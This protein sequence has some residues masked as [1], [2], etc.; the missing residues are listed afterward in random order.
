MAR[1]I[2][3]GAGI[4]GL[5]CAWSAQRRGW[6]VTLVDRDFE[7][8]RAS[9]GNAGSIAV[10]EC[11]P[12]SLAGLGLQPLRWLVDPLGPLSIRATHAPR[13]LPWFMALRKVG[14]GANHDRIAQTLAAINARALPDLKTLLAD[15]GLGAELHRHGALTVYETRRALE[16]DAEAWAL[17]RT[18]GVRWRVIH[19]AELRSLEPGLAPVFE[20]AVMLEDCAHVSDPKRIVER[21]R[22][23]VQAL[24]AELVSGRVSAVQLQGQQASAVLSDGRALPADRLLVAAGAW[25]ARLAGTLGDR[26]LLAAERGYN[27]TLP[28]SMDRLKREIIFAERKFVATPLSVGLRVGGAAEFAGL[29]AAPNYQ[30]S[31]A[32]LRLARRYLVDLDENG[33]TQWMGQRPATPDSLPVIGPSPRAPQVMYAFGHGHL[34]LTQAAA[35]GELIGDLLDGT[36]PPIDLAPCSIARFRA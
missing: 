30:R 12:L 20:R 24:G 13:L 7:G 25:S 35:T 4:V 14:A 31:E 33:A 10:G 16:R 2:I 21:L 19:A 18:L 8:D 34:G 5:A 17:K 26:A 36:P 9:H 32:L 1:L 11:L 15:I 27:T 3:I 28:R 29:E 6:Q 23:R 22:A